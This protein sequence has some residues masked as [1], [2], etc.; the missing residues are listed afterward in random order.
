[1]CRQLVVLKT[2]CAMVKNGGLS[3][4]DVMLAEAQAEDYKKM[5]ERM[6]NLEK[7]V[8]A[9]DKKVDAVDVKLDRVLEA[10]AHEKSSVLAT[11][12]SVL[13]NRVFIYLLIT[14]VCT[15][16]GVSVGEVGTFLWK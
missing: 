1:M 3:K 9:V 8:D 11:I 2:L 12:K 14:L 5:E 6:T 15:A 4:C 13:S 10:L 7:K 16:F